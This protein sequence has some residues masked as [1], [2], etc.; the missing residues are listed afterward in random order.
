MVRFTNGHRIVWTLEKDELDPGLSWQ[1]D[2]ERCVYRF[3]WRSPSYFFEIPFENLR[4]EDGKFI[5]SRV[6]IVAALRG[7]NM[8]LDKVSVYFKREFISHFQ[9]EDQTDQISHE[10][11]MAAWNSLFS[12]T[13]EQYA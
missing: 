2:T 12:F 5:T 1:V 10:D 6:D 13:E 11:L 4:F 9:D 8:Q 7:N 3:Q